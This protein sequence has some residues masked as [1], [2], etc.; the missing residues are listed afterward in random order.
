MGLGKTF[1]KVKKKIHVTF[2]AVK[3]FRKKPVRDQNAVADNNLAGYGKELDSRNQIPEPGPATANVVRAEDTEPE[4]GI[5]E[6]VPEEGPVTATEEQDPVLRILSGN[7]IDTQWQGFI[8]HATDL[9]TNVV[10]SGQTVTWKTPRFFDCTFSTGSI[11]QAFEVPRIE[12]I[13]DDIVVGLQS[14]GSASN[15]I[16]TSSLISTFDIKTEGAAGVIR[17]I[18]EALST[19]AVGAAPTFSIATSNGLKNGSWI[20]ILNPNTVEV[21]YT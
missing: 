20:K 11:Q 9:I 7:S 15:N 3:A 1:Q 2:H 19:G 21:F 14:V 16:S 8:D 13:D 10:V 4:A 6:N 5:K 17:S 18:L 12:N